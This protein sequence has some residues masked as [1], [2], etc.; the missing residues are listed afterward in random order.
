MTHGDISEDCLYLN[1]WTPTTAAGE[2]HPV[3]FW[4]WWLKQEKI[5]VE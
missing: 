3:F 4:M 5:T 2:K 1:I